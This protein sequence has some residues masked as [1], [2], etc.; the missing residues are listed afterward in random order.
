MVNRHC[1]RSQQRQDMPC[2]G[3]LLCGAS[4]INASRSL[5]LCGLLASLALSHTVSC[6]CGGASQRILKVHVLTGCSS[7]HEARVR[8]HAAARL[9]QRAALLPCA[10]EFSCCHECL[11][12]QPA[13][14]A[15]EDMWHVFNLVREGDRVTGTTFRKVAKESGTGAESERV[16]IRLAIQVEGVEFDP[17]GTL[18][19]SAEDAAEEPQ[20]RTSCCSSGCVL[21]RLRQAPGQSARRLADAE[22]KTSRPSDA[23]APRVA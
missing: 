2:C 12:H 3:M 11:A 9:C 20:L 17:E 1:S 7:Q 23:A 13:V 4:C 19:N 14:L 8:P 10:V 6:C 5:Q 22:L 18:P 16:K 15:A 21:C